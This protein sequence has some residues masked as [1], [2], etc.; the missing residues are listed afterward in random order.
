[1]KKCKIIQ[2][3][4]QFVRNDPHIMHLISGN[5]S[6]IG[7]KS[8]FHTFDVFRPTLNQL[9]VSLSEVLKFLFDLLTKYLS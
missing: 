4:A 6:T 5:E 3:K 9:N 2:S 1:M 7:A 8:K